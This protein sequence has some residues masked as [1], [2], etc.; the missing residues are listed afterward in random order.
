VAPARAPIADAVGEIANSGPELA[1]LGGRLGQ[2]CDVFVA[3]SVAGGTGAGFFYDYL[4][5]L[6]DVFQRTGFRAQV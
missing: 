2:M 6:G 5:L 3:F 1:A 4:H